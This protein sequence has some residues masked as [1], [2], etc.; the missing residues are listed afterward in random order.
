VIELGLG[1]ALAGLLRRYGNPMSIERLQRLETA[2]Q[3]ERPQL[4][5]VRG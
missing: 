3:S 1:G 5:L 4:R 2:D